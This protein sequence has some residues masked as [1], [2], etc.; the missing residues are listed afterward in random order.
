MSKMTELARGRPC[1]IRLDGCLSG[2]ENE[3]T[4]FAHLNGAGIG[5]KNRVGGFDW[6]APLCYHCHST[7]DGQISHN[8]DKEW[9]EL[10][11]LRAT[12]RFQKKLA[13]EEKIFI[14]TRKNGTL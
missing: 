10:L 14:I 3:T 12:F 6:G 13:Q 5:M 4:V 7:V 1:E 9:L 2:G 11:H 8:Y